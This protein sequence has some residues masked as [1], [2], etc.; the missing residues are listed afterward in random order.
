ML[1]WGPHASHT[2]SG[3]GQHS[4]EPKLTTCALCYFNIQFPCII[5]ITALR[6]Q[7]LSQAMPAPLQ[8]NRASSFVL[9]L[10][11]WEEQVLRFADGLLYQKASGRQRLEKNT[12][13]FPA[14]HS[15][16]CLP[17]GDTSNCHWFVLAFP[18][19]NHNIRAFVP[20][21]DV[22]FYGRTAVPVL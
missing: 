18:L 4:T 8:P 3:A 7:Y 15:P 17:W 14:R 22:R 11:E 10:P 13:A 6:E 12:S 21:R 1:T 5:Y 20:H 16:L 19:Q 2:C 9:S